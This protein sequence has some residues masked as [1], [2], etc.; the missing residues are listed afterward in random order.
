[1]LGVV[2]VLNFTNK[3]ALKMLTDYIHLLTDYTFC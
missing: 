2:S 1:M 3:K